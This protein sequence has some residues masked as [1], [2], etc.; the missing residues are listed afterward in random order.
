MNKKSKTCF[1]DLSGYPEELKGISVYETAEI[2]DMERMLELLW[3][4]AADMKRWKLDILYHY[5]CE[6]EHPT[7]RLP[8]VNL[9]NYML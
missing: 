4:D 5:L 6:T 8:P 7:H 2:M 1:S 3:P 9:Y